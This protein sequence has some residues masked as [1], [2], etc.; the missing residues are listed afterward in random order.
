MDATIVRETRNMKIS[1][2]DITVKTDCNSDCGGVAFEW[3]C[4]KCGLPVTWS[5]FMWWDLTCEY[6]CYD[7]DFDVVANYIEIS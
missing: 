1:F 3:K 7:W 6:K 2:K 4:P 5:P